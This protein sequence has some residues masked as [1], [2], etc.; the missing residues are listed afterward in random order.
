[1]E[2]EYFETSWKVK[3]QQFRRRVWYL[4]KEAKRSYKKKKGYT[5]FLTE[6]EQTFRFSK[7]DLV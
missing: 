6:E 7:F 5:Q 1:M 2:S 3:L 4:L